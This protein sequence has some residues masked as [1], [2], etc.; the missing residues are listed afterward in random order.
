MSTIDDKESQMSVGGRIVVLW[1]GHENEHLR[2]GEGCGFVTGID[3]STDISESNKYR[4]TKVG[5]QRKK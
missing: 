2:G 1:I 4:A 3:R 5:E